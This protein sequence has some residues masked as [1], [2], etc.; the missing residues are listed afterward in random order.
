MPQTIQS[1]TKGEKCFYILYNR[2]KLGKLIF[3]KGK[4]CISHIVGLYPQLNVKKCLID[5]IQEINNDLDF[6]SDLK[7]YFAQ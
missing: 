4:R 6:V 3:E 5:N 1:I 7:W 2:T